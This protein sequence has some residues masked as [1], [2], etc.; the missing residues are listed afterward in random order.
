[1]KIPGFI[2]LCSLI[3]FAIIG[4]CVAIK[5]KSAKNFSHRVHTEKGISCKACHITVRKDSLAGMPKERKC[6][7]CHETINKGVSAEK[8]YTLNEWKSTREPNL[9]IFADVK[10]SHKKHLENGRVCSDC[11]N[12]VADSDT[13]TVEHMPNVN[14][15]VQCH[16]QWLNDTQCVKCHIK[17]RLTT[18]PEDHER[19]DFMMV[20]G[21]K[22]KDKPFDNWMEGTGRHSHLCFQCHKQDHCITCHNEMPPRDHTNQ[23]RRVG[24]GVSAGINRNSCQTCHRSDFCFRCHE[25]TRPASHVANWGATRSR[26]CAH[27]HEPLSSNNCIVCHK[28]TPSHDRA[29]FAPT[30]VRRGSPCRSCHYS[31]VPL[32]HFDNGEDCENCHKTVRPSRRQ[33][34]RRGRRR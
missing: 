8:I 28:S 26:H 21:K 22:L 30:F 32:D 1:M 2:I 6:I 31:V 17:T 34:R 12:N 9:K 14:T 16:G 5:S 33:E 3:L 29:P 20:H 25:R 24:H 13:L 23:W 27:C 10:F 4:G 15:C 11:H 19:V 7:M 18:K